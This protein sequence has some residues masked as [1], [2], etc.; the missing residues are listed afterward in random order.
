M[1]IS[2]PALLGLFKSN[3]SASTGRV[4]VI[5]ATAS[6][7]RS[8]LTWILAC[9]AKG[10]IVQFRLGK[11]KRKKKKKKKKEKK[12]KKEKLGPL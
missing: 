1:F 9:S 6:A 5:G 7:Y 2:S 10:Q 11:Q 8:V 12:E 3:Q 4:D